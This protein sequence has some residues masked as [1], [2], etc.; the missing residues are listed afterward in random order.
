MECRAM[1]GAQDV[2]FCSL[3]LL[4]W[5]KKKVCVF[6]SEEVFVK[7]VPTVQK[8]KTIGSQMEK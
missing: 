2:F 5:G 3:L 7:A 1:C 6:C 8:K 4:L